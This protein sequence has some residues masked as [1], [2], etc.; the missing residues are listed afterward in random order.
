MFPEKDS[1][2]K[3]EN[4]DKKFESPLVLFFDFESLQKPTGTMEKCVQ[5]RFACKCEASYTLGKLDNFNLNIS[6]AIKTNHL[7]FSYFRY[8][9]TLAYNLQFYNCRQK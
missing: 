2:M 1:Y 9:Y 6:V 7:Y 3:W 8:T 5:C 4:F